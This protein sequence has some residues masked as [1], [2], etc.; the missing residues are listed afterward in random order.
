[1]HEVYTVLS[2]L[3]LRE[4]ACFLEWVLGVSSSCSPSWSSGTAGVQ[5]VGQGLQR[6]PTPAPVHNTHIYMCV[7]CAHGAHSGLCGGLEPAPRV[8]RPPARWPGAV[9]AGPEAPGR[10]TV[11][12]VKGIGPSHCPHPD[13]DAALMLPEDLLEYVV[14]RHLPARMMP[15]PLP[16]P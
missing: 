16:C 1:M 5:G 9:L 4:W 6:G 11:T 12:R 8:R 13:A 2:R 7:L 15:W 14:A 3:P 10:L